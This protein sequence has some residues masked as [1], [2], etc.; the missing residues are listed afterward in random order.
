M[1]VFGRVLVFLA[2]R[3]IL[4]VLFVGIICGALVYYYSH[5]YVQIF[6]VLDE[7]VSHAIKRLSAYYSVFFLY[8]MNFVSFI[9]LGVILSMKTSKHEPYLFLALYV[10]HTFLFLI[11]GGLLNEIPMTANDYVLI[12]LTWMGGAIAVFLATKIAAR[13]ETIIFY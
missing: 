7:N 6:F 13:I 12:G 8:S 4:S 9:V 2:V 5:A 1:Y 11:G 10:F 3:L